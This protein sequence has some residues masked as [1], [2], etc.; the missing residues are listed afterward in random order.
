MHMSMLAFISISHF[1]VVVVAL[2]SSRK[3]LNQEPKMKIGCNCNW[4]YRFIHILIAFILYKYKH[5]NMYILVDSF[6]W[7]LVVVVVF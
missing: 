3:K 5:I 2:I 7:V 6:T 1:F 4:F